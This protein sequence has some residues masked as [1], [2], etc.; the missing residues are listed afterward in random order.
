MKNKKIIA[1]LLELGVL[2]ASSTTLIGCGESSSGGSQSTGGQGGSSGSSESG[3]QQTSFSIK[4]GTV[5]TIENVGYG[6]EKVDKITLPINI[7]Q[8][9]WGIFI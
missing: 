4:N 5:T 2:A 9:Y 8:F 1:I 7:P 6:S 3:E